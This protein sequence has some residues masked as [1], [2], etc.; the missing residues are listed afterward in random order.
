MSDQRVAEAT[1]VSG[2]VTLGAAT[3]DAAVGAGREANLW[4]DAWRL[5]RRR[6][7]FVI[8]AVLVAVL[9]LVAAF[10]Q[11]FARGINPR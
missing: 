11:I 9:I 10:P 2:D 7:M 8:P 5:L 3:A 4:N 1:D 6:P